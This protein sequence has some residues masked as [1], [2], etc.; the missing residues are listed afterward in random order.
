MK[1]FVI[2]SMLSLST[3]SIAADVADFK[4]VANVIDSRC[5]G[6]HDSASHK[7]GIDLESALTSGDFESHKSALLW[8][9]VEKAVRL[10]EMPPKSK[11]PL[12]ADQKDSILRWF[13]GQYILSH[14]KEHI[15]PTTLR[16]LSRYE[17]INTRED[18]LHLSLKNP[19]I[20][21]PE[22]PSLLPS[23]LE[24]MLPPDVPGESGFFND[25]H[26]LASIKPPILKYIDAFDYVLR[27]FA[28]DAQAREAVFGFKDIPPALA[29]AKAREILQRFMTRAWRGYKNPQIEQAVMDAYRVRRKSEEAGPSLLHAMKACL[30]APPFLYRMEAVENKSVPYRVGSYELANRLSYFLWASMPDDELLRL[31]ADKSLLKESVL[32]AQVD[33]MLKS[34]KRI[35]IAE[36]F[37]GQW[38]G[39][40]DLRTK[41]VFYQNE[42]WNRGV[43]DELLFFFDELV[44]SDQSVLNIVDSDWVYQSEY[45]KVKVQGKSHIFPSIH[46]N[47]FED[48]QQ[49]PSGLR[50]Q[51][52]KPPVLLKINS[53]ERGGIITSVG[54]MRVTSPPESTNPIR[55]GVWMLDKIIGRPMHAPD[56]IPPLS[57]SEKVEGKKLEDV[58][59]ILKAHTNKA[60]CISCHKHIDPIGLGLEKFDTN[61]LWREKYP[62]KRPIQAQGVFP[63]GGTFNTP[64]EMKLVLLEEY[65]ESIARNIIE[66]MLSYAIGR[67]LKPY[68]RITVDNI[69]AALV[70]DGYK[71]N[72]LIVQIIQSK[73]FLY[74]QDQP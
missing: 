54:I 47:I 21:S 20:Y 5:V 65:R 36:D 59:E 1:S 46:G 58:A 10:G 33:R 35:S 17:L 32:L 74:R 67:K 50:E 53:Q 37:A 49:R 29:D 60:A 62:N 26:Q 70:R 39:F 73:Q 15:G 18:I 13:E 72:S 22:V 24:T 14:G 30:L 44:K 51:F 71:M 12:S 6:C 48:R 16:R 4:L 64:K 45:T 27:G 11:E 9:R 2:A 63:N 69:H 28:Q 40:D 8:E 7:G 56:N 52:Y 57:E 34:P 43:Y 23:A 31:A 41:K 68:D 66:R 25:A 61:G 42:R 38:L 55:R 3:A 19:Y